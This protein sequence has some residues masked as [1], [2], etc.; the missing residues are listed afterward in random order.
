MK[1]YRFVVSMLSLIFAVFSVGCVSCSSSYPEM[2]VDSAGLQEA[3]AIA[4]SALCEKTLN[5]GNDY[6]LIAAQQFVV[7]GRYIWRVT[8][9]SGLPKDPS[10]ELM[11]A[12]GE[13]FVN[14][15][16]LTKK[17]EIWHGD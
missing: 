10:K 5:R 2:N 12:G 17:A 14:I 11:P 7:K 15:D 16:P 8:F 6:T 1:I 9:K 4:K 3:I 13:I